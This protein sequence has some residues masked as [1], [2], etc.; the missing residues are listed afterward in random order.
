MTG[1]YFKYALGEIVLVVIGILIALQINAWNETRKNHEQETVLLENL[2]KQLKSD[3]KNINNNIKAT[4]DRL[5]R[6]DTIL[7]ML[8]E[9][10]KINKLEF[11]NRSRDFGFDSYFSCNCSI[12][13]EAVSSGKMSLVQNSELLESI[14]TYYTRRKEDSN[15]DSIRK[16]TDD[17]IL[18]LLIRTLYVN[19]TG[20]S[21]LQVDTKELD[22]AS[23][24]PDIDFK[25]L[26]SNVQFWEMVFAKKAGN[27]TQ[28]R[29]WNSIRKNAENLIEAIALEQKEL[30]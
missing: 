27:D 9:P 16:L 23:E 10:D 22:L 3:V 21:L 17:F 29:T 1:K 18:P 25:S 11:L 19:Q 7:L 14:F 2:M 15:D 13:D 26:K 4:E 20:I 5:L 28:I 8:T 30:Q 12:F 24:L 6:L